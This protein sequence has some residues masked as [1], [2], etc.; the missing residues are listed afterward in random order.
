MEPNVY[1]TPYPSS[2]RL[3]C[4]HFTS[5]LQE[6]DGFVCTPRRVA[7]ITDALVRAVARA[8]DSFTLRVCQ[9]TQ[10]NKLSK[11]IL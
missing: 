3:M 7:R 6:I 10:R 2:E 1:K 9:N 5:C 8:T 11:K 4:V